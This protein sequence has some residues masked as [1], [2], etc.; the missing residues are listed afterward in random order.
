L[1]R[2]TGRIKERKMDY[3]RREKENRKRSDLIFGVYNFY[4]RVLF[5]DFSGIY[6]SVVYHT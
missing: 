3:E 5:I 1:F 4:T 6:T 2:I